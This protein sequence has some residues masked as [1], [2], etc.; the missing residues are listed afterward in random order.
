METGALAPYERALLSA[1]PVRLRTLEGDLVELDVPRWLAPVD[2]ADESVLDRCHGPV[3]DDEHRLGQLEL[4]HDPVCRASWG[5][6]VP[7]DRLTYLRGHSVTVTITARR[8]ATG[9]TGT[10]HTTQFDGQPVFGNILLDRSGCVEASVIVN[11]VEGGG[12]ATT[13][14]MQ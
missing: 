12:T 11:A 3:L 4:R 10:S 5:R 13:A 2:A 8:P 6:F 1:R 7:S 14:C 9:T